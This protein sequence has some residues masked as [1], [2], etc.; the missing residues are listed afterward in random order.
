[1][2]MRIIRV[3]TRIA[4]PFFVAGLVSAQVSAPKIGMA[5]YSD[6]TVWAILGLPSNLILGNESLSYAD[7]IS[8]SDFG[9]LVSSHGQIQLLGP[10]L[11]VVGEYDSSEA[12]PV[13]NVDGGLTSAIAWL[14]SESKLLHWDGKSF[15]ATETSSSLFPGRV[16][17]V[18]LENNSLAKLLVVQSDQSVAEV[19]ISL[20]KGNLLGIAVVPGVSGPAIQEPGFVLFQDEQGLEIESASGELHTLAL[21]AHDLTIERMSSDWL[22]LASPSSKRNWALHMTGSQFDLSVLPAPAAR[23]GAFGGES[24]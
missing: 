12:A 23:T 7:A 15:I 5:K 19:T 20:D 4:L 22:H 6:G 11:H 24:K 8:F 13:L 16:S 18:R 3:V 2:K 21:P 9:G 17:S 14:P 10:D 1:M